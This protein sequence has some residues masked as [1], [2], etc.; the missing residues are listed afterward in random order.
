M[1]FLCCIA[2]FMQ[3]SSF[4]Q[5]SSFYT[6]LSLSPTNQYSQHPYHYHLQA[7]LL[8]PH[9]ISPSSCL[10]NPSPILLLAP[11]NMQQLHTH[12]HQPNMERFLRA[13]SEAVCTLQHVCTGQNDNKERPPPPSFFKR[14]K[15]ARYAQLNLVTRHSPVLCKATK[16]GHS[17]HYPMTDYYIIDFCEHYFSPLLPLPSPPPPP[18]YPLLP[19]HLPSTASD[20]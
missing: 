11:N 20:P 17:N 15:R 8:P 14:Q 1:Y 12:T 6:S 4:P 2:C 16:C 10:K 9:H 3:N 13:A 5:C 18:P 7:T 19:L